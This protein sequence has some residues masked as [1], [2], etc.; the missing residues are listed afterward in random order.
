MILNHCLAHVSWAP[1]MSFSDR[2]YPTRNSLL[3]GKHPV[4]K[5]DHYRTIEEMYRLVRIWAKLMAVSPLFTRSALSQGRAQ[6]LHYGMLKISVLLLQQ[7][8]H[9]PDQYAVNVPVK[10]L[11][12]HSAVL[13]AMQVWVEGLRS[14]S[15][16]SRHHHCQPHHQ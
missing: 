10:L 11:A 13:K 8:R 14:R 2:A 6:S 16:P 9:A 5:W 1:M 7:L 15:N 12:P 3:V 4:K